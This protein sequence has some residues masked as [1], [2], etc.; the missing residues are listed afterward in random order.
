L[1]GN[2]KVDSL[3]IRWPSGVTHLFTGLDAN[4][5]V[6]VKEDEQSGLA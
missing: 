6:S 5:I 3:E 2:A 1:S 4:Q